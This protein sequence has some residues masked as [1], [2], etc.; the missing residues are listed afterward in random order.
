M[1][2]AST[3]RKAGVPKHDPL[4]VQMK[5]ADINDEGV[6]SQPGKRQKRNKKTQQQEEVSGCACTGLELWRREL[7]LELRNA[8]RV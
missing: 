8:M 5:E 4:G 6:L 1:P 7:T 2:K 3:G